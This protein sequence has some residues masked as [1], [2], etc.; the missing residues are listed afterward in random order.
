MKTL[1]IIPTLLLDCS[2]S[3]PLAWMF[4]KHADR[5]KGVYGFELTRDMVLEHEQFIVELNWFVELHEFGLIVDFI[6]RNNR[7]A[8]ILFGGMYAG[9][10]HREIFQRY[11]VDHF[12]LGD[13]EL[14]IGLF[15]ESVAPREIPNC[16]GR[17]FANPISYAFT[18]DQYGDLDFDLSRFPSYFK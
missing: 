13:N 9:I 10:R 4:A 11:D 5:V 16:V 2:F 17:D 1:V 7:S 3:A 15:V 12:I 8:K 14:P 6:R 18:E